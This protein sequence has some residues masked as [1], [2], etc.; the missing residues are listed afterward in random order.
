MNFLS[1]IKNKNFIII[2]SKNMNYTN[3]MKI[4]NIN[5]IFFIINKIFNF[6]YSIRSNFSKTKM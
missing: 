2:F 6:I 4:L 5:I 3:S 1:I